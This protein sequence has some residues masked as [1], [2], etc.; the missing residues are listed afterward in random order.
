MQVIEADSQPI[1]KTQP[2]APD[3]AY[4]LVHRAPGSWRPDS[5]ADRPAEQQPRWP[6]PDAVETVAEEISLLPPLVLPTEVQQLHRSLATVAS[7][8]AFLLQAGDCAE[9]FS[10]CTEQGVRGKLR[11]I[12]QLAILLT[13]GSG[14]PVVKVGRIAGQFAKPRSTDVETVAG[15]ELPVFRGDI[16]N[17]PEPTAQARRPEPERMLRAYHNASAT[18]NMLQALTKEG[19]AD[20]DQVHAWNQEFVRRSPAGR[21]YEAVADDITWALRFMSACGTEQV[22]SQALHQVQLFTSHEALLPRFEQALTRFDVE[23]GAWFGTSAHMLWV[24]DRTRKLDGAHIEYLSG[25]ANPVGIKI[26]PSTTPSELLA[27]CERL[28]PEHLPGRL[29]LISRMGAQRINSE[30]PPLVRAVHDSGH[31]VVWSCDPMHGNTFRSA[32]GYKTR[33]LTDIT[34][35]I[36]GFFA[37][38]GEAGVHPGGMHLE[39]TGEDVTECLGGADE[40]LD[41]HLCTR[42]ETACDPR[43]NAS[44]SIELAFRVAELLREHHG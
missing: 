33:H 11:V 30:L 14:L 39:M 25:L 15:Q 5:W 43:L 19:F 3:P 32:S 35:E 17:S 24:G 26:G 21:D 40:V 34:A 36:A 6:N 9:Q 37:V 23:T 2:A 16:V 28:D 13:Y 42:Y 20:L 31:P 41:T 8:R 44:Q 10:S 12:L 4:P 27:L 22:S 7:G 29:V 18:L 38:L 1:E